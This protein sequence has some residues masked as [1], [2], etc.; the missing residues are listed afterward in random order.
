VSC[1]GT[2]DDTSGAIKAFAAARNNAFTLLVDC[3]V[4]LHSGLAIDRGIFIDSGTSVQFTASGKFLVDN[5]FHPAFVIANSSQITLTNWNV[6]W[7]GSV[8]VDPNFGGYELNGEFVASPG[9]TQPAGAFND[10]VLTAWLAANRSITFDEKKGRVESIWVGGVN[11]AAVFFITGDSSSVVFSGLKLY[12]PPA[13]GGNAFMPMA[14]SLS[15]NWKSKQTVTGTTPETTQY[16]AVPHGITF[17]GIDLDGIYMGWQGNLQDSL[18]E[19]I[20]SHRYGDLQDAKGKNVGGIGKWYPPPHLFYINT[21]AAD[22]GLDN[23]NVHFSNITDEGVRVGVARDTPGDSGSGFANS[24]KLSCTDCSVDTYTSHRPD[25]FMDV[26]AADGMTVS[27]VTATFDSQFINNLY[28]AGLRF[29]MTS[30]SHVTFENLNL[31]D[32]ADSTIQ[33]PIGN[34]TSAANRTIVFSG[35]SITMNKWAGSDMPLPSLTGTGNHV[36][37]NFTMSAQAMKLAFLET[38]SMTVWVAGTPAIVR[39]DGS[40]VIKWDS[41]HAEKCSANGAWAGTIAGSGSRSVAVSAAGSYPFT[42]NCQSAGGSA[43]TT[44]SVEAQQ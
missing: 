21:H 41:R 43:D 22:A 25:G 35:V 12:V 11:P 19:N 2:T 24:L 42:L 36:A 10:L 26:L 6:E 39:P 38:G 44:M 20:T 8:P 18:F 34:S 17:S 4:R 1:T 32:T 27:N 29:P 28:P 40:T 37:I 14:I 15:A 30:Y 16:A 31:T 9:E 33:G 7:D 13:A 3:P 5:M 23:I